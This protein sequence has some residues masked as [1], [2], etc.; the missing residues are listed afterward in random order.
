MSASF[1]GGGGTAGKGYYARP[2][3]RREGLACS[4]ARSAAEEEEEQ[5][6]LG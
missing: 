1:P 6:L 3:G 4:L 2:G 5:L